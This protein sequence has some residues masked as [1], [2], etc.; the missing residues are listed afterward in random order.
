MKFLHDPFNPPFVQGDGQRV[1]RPS[2]S[3]LE[4]AWQG[5]TT[6]VSWKEGAPF[7]Q[8]Y[9]AEGNLRGNAFAQHMREIMLAQIIKLGSPEMKAHIKFLMGTYS[10]LV[11]AELKFTPLVNKLAQYGDYVAF[12]GEVLSVAETL[13]SLV[14][15]ELSDWQSEH[16]AKWYQKAFEQKVNTFAWGPPGSDGKPKQI[17]PAP[18]SIRV[19]EQDVNDQRI[20]PE[21]RAEFDRFR[22]ELGF[23]RLVAKTAS[24][25]MRVG[26]A[27]A[28]S[29][30]TVS[31]LM[32]NNGA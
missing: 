15:E 24:V 2:P 14:D 32:K 17:Y 31:N 27:V 6:V 19:T 21:Y 1:R 26:M 3:D 10:D 5:Y 22:M 4:T 23:L 25:Y 18:S 9:D 16:R 11:D 29:N 30:A 7:F 12:L 13:G 8:P 20:Q 28:V